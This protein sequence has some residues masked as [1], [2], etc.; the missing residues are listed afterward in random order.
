MDRKFAGFILVFFL[1]IGIIGNIILS[2]IPGFVQVDAQKAF[3]Y[4]VDDQIVLVLKEGPYAIEGTKL[5][6]GCYQ[7]STPEP[8]KIY[9]AA[10]M[11]WPK[12]DGFL[13]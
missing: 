1:I 11:V 4:P 3:V 5:I 7:L 12:C 10:H 13:H 2:Q 9:G 8:G 6:S